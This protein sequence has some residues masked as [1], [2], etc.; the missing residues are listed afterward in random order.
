MTWQPIP[1]LQTLAVDSRAD[2]TLYCGT[3][4]CGKTAAQ[5]MFFLLQ[6]GRGWGEKFL[7]IIFDTEYKSLENIKAQ[8]KKFFEP[9]GNCVFKESPGLYYFEW[10]TGERLYL[11]AATSYQEAIKYLGHE[12]TYIFFNEL[13]KWQN[14]DLYD[15][16][17]G[18]MRVGMIRGAP[19][20]RIFS[21]TNPYGPGTPW[22]K[23][24]F[25]LPKPAGQ[26]MKETF[27]VPLGQGRYQE[28]VKSKVV[29][30]GNYTQNPYFR[31]EDIANLMESCRNDP[32][33][34]RAWLFCDWNA[35]YVDGAF[36]D[37]W[38]ENIHVVPDFPI[39]ASWS[40]NRTLDWAST[41]PFAVCWFAESNGEE[42]EH[43][44]K[45]YCYPRGSVIQFSELYGSDDGQIGR[46]KGSRL[47]PREVALAIKERE[48]QLYRSGILDERCTIFGG[49]ADNQIAAIP[50]T[51][52]DSIE[53]AFGREGVYW[54]QSD[55]SSGSRSNGF[56]L[57]RDALVNA[58]TKEGPGYYVQ[59]RCP[60]TIELIPTL[61]KQRYEEDIEKG[62]EDHLYDAIRYRILDSFQAE[63][64]NIAFRFG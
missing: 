27:T 62:Q 33:R 4:G 9:M 55:K 39:P 36:G 26:L 7:G 52:F 61:Q 14:S 58:K 64:I 2:Q 45:R 43:K 42:I 17:L 10:K 19:P 21:T 24:R 50:R 46:N 15:H 5:L 59:Q 34:Q 38:K 37:V 3:R 12:Y 22:I 30:S 8:G 54:S 35:A 16:M 49:P 23:R 40:V 31:P 47:A 32:E 48:Q 60:V 1:G 18:T 51:D 57:F 25:I 6:V 13:S 41:T 53:S 29:I 20:T 56:N 44:G 28:V 11:R 63:V